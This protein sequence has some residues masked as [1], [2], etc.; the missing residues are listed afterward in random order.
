MER[1]LAIDDSRS[2]IHSLATILGRQGYEFAYAED[3]AA[4]LVMCRSFKPDLILL[5]AEMPIL[6]GFEV[7]ADLKSNPQT[8]EIPVI[9][10]S[11]HDDSTHRVQAFT[12][13]AQD[14]IAKPFH[15]REVLLRVDTQ[16]K[17]LKAQRELVQARN[18]AQQANQA[19]TLFLSRMSH[20]LRTPLNSILGYARLLGKDERLAADVLERMDIIASSGEH[21]L[22][23]VNDLIQ[24]AELDTDTPALSELDIDIT[25]VLQEVLQEFAQSC[26]RLRVNFV[27][28]IHMRPRQVAHLD[29][30]L[31]RVLLKNLLRAHRSLPVVGRIA[32][33]AVGVD[34]GSTYLLRLEVQATDPRETPAHPHTRN[35]AEETSLE[36]ALLTRV[37]Q[38]LGGTFN[39]SEV[40]PEGSVLQ[41]ELPLHARVGSPV[42]LLDESM[43]Y[44]VWV[45]RS[46][47]VASHPLVRQVAV[48]ADPMQLEEYLHS[49]VNRWVIDAD[50]ALQQ[51]I[52]WKMYAQTLPAGTSLE[53]HA[54]LAQPDS[55]REL[56][57]Y[58]LGCYSCGSWDDLSAQLAVRA[59]TQAQTPEPTM[60]TLGDLDKETL[61]LLHQA[62]QTLDQVALLKCAQ[63][64]SEHHAAIAQWIVACCTAYD[65]AQI[66]NALEVLP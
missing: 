22:G 27:S 32:L 26:S 37:V 39:R 18:A 24:F 10:L 66:E 25:A 21:L 43:R 4:G 65:F 41:V 17:A 48:F 29:P 33:K 16:L 45:R 58:K 59:Y 40:S 46:L 62:A 15:E 13:G 31:F 50:V 64:L 60:P 1:I 3:G 51:M 11:G 44:D 8:L 28:E 5:D 36:M 52:D 12:A 7:C 56:S 20:E 30:S 9:F 53:V 42:V 2:V 55:L 19:K 61:A 14:F 63:N 57:L 47:G 38:V 6:N 35:Y 49:G 23:M 54:L 34:R